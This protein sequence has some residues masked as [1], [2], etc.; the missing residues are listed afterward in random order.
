MTISPNMSVWWPMNISD[1]SR[2][3]VG[4]EMINIVTINIGN[5]IRVRFSLDKG[6]QSLIDKKA[7]VRFTHD[8]FLGCEFLDL[9]DEEKELGFYLFS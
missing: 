2:T 9:A 6:Q 8:K 3:G 7:I 1:L 4:F 5:I